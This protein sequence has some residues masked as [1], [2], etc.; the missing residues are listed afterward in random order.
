MDIVMT[1][2]SVSS[3][4]GGKWR[5]IR[6][7]A[8][9]PPTPHTPPPTLSLFN[10]P[11]PPHSLAYTTLIHSSLTQSAL[12][13][14]LSLLSLSTLSTLHSIPTHSTHNTRSLLSSSDPWD[15][16]T[17]LLGGSPVSVIGPG[18][19]VVVHEGVYNGPFESHIQGI[20]LFLSREWRDAE[21]REWRVEESN[22]GS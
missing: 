5:S 18:S 15:L 20:G 11:T 19:V 10:S 22:R 4:L 6:E 12:H 7:T 14:S 16:A 21:S 1:G 9:S 13:C 3:G 17:A 2:R 8:S